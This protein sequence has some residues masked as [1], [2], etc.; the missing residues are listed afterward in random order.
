MQKHLWKGLV[1][2]A[3]AALP[4][5][6]VINVP[7][8]GTG[9]SASSSSS[10]RTSSATTT[11]S[12][13]SSTGSTTSSTSASSGTGGGPSSD[14]GNPCKADADCNTGACLS[15]TTTGYPFGACSLMDC[16]PL[17]P[18]CDN[19]NG[20]CIPDKFQGNRCLKACTMG[21]NQCGNGYACM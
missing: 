3:A 19:G 9:G 14:L 15:E 1:I 12:T 17:L 11:G 13:T 20:F 18:S 21:G 16:D 4:A 10:E 7:N 2:L 6:C 5:S 8:T